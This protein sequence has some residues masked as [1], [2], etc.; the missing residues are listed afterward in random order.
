MTASY[1]FWKWADNDLPGRPDEVHAS[2]LRGRMHP[3]IQPF[4][5]S[6]LVKLLQ[7]DAAR[8]REKGEEW[9]WQIVWEQEPR[10]AKFVFV[11]L[12]TPPSTEPEKN[13]MARRYLRQVVFGWSGES[14]TDFAG[15][16]PK[17]NV[18]LPGGGSPCVWDPS[19]ADLP[20][21]IK[22]L[23]PSGEK[24]HA[25]LMNHKND[26]V[27]IAALRGRF[28]VEWRDADYMK[29]WDAF[30]HWHLR[31][32]TPARTL[33]GRAIQRRF[34][35]DGLPIVR[36]YKGKWFYRL[37]QSHEFELICPSDVLA[38]LQAFMHREPRPSFF[39]WVS[40]TEEMKHRPADYMPWNDDF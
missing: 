7:K 28:T 19:T 32:R 2:L 31:Y 25:M 3:A 13:R 33:K 23:G 37:T 30:E 5:P 16:L 40:L 15:S 18:W 17:Q 14:R 24:G 11:T 10:H 34:V 35:P 27:Q 20:R 9:D 1:Y 21:L 38:L 6:P 4:D 36:N 39:E 22:D 29:S 12:P 8:G 26:Y